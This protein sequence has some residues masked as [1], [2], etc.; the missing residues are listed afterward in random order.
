M[1]K[2]YAAAAAAFV[3]ILLVILLF[4]WQVSAEERAWCATAP[5]PLLAQYG[6]FDLSQVGDYGSPWGQ[7]CIAAYKATH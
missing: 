7:A 5:T 4:T 2:W 6:D 3:T 1:L